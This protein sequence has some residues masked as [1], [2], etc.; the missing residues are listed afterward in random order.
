MPRNKK[1][2][3]GIKS[4]TFASVIRL[5]LASPIFEDLAPNT[6]RW[7]RCY[8]GVAE[9]RDGLG[10]KS[11]EELHPG[12][13]QDFLDAFHGRPGAQRMA[14]DALVA[15]TRWAVVKRLLP[16]DITFGTRVTGKIKGH[17]PWTDEQ[18]AF[19]ESAVSPFLGRAITLGANTGQRGSD[20]V[21][22]RWTDIEF[23]E[24]WPGIKVLQQKTKKLLWIPFTRSLREKIEGWERRPGFILLRSNGEPWKRTGLTDAWIYE[25]KKHPTLQHL[26]LHGLRATAVVRLWRGGC[27]IPDICSFVGMTKD[28]VETYVKNSEQ[29][30]NALA[31]IIRLEGRYTRD[32]PLKNKG[33]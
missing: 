4:G 10:G 23:E 13:V 11:V 25:K 17:K 33:S 29:R 26:N 27:T 32:N 21:T 6:Q 14:R 12:D 9:L 7:Q 8:L 31:A 19:A 28:T 5:Y 16:I 22:M 24:G 18:V 3:A 30:Q 20:L 2:Y 1:S 15:V